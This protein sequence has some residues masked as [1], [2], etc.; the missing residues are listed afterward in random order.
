V[1]VEVIY[2]QIWFQNQIDLK[3]IKDLEKEKI[4]SIFPSLMGRNPAN[5][6]SQPSQPALQTT[7]HSAT[8]AQRLAGRTPTSL[9]EF[10][11]LSEDPSH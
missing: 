10:D 11:P 1:R 7:Q 8:V 4:F 5:P 6:P 9:G 3:F 2:I